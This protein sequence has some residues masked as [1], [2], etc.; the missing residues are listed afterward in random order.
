MSIFNPDF[1]PTPENVIDMMLL[2][3]TIEGKVILEPS[4]GNG[5]IIKYLKTNGAKDV[6]FC[7][8]E[9][10][11]ATISSN[12][13]R[14]VGDDFLKLN[15]EDVSHIDMIVANPPFS[16]D[17]DH[18]LKMWDIAPGGCT[19]ITLLNWNTYDLAHTKARRLLRH[20]V[21]ENGSATYLGDVFSTAERKTGVAIGL[22]KLYKPKT[23]GDDEFD[24]YFD[25]SEE[26]EQQENGLMGYNEVRNIVNRYVG[27][28]KMF[29]EV[30]DVNNKIN[31]LIK[32]ISSGL[33][34]EFGAR[35]RKHYTIERD[36]FKKELQKSAWRTVFN[37]LNMRKYTTERVMSQLNKFVEQ[38]EKVPFTM[39]NIYKMIEMIIGTH[40]DR[41]GR[42]LVEVFDWL[43]ERHKEN[44]VGLEG[45]KT[46]SMYFVGM[47]FVAPYCGLERGY[48]GQPQI[49]YSSS[50]EKMDDLT[51]AICFLTGKDYNGFETLSEFFREK[52]VPNDDAKKASEL[53]AQETGI[54]EKEADYVHNYASRYAAEITP[55]KY[56]QRFWN[57]PSKFSKDQIDKFK[58][59]YEKW[60]FP[61][62][63]WGK[64]YETKNWGQ[65]YDWGF[66]EIKVYKKGTLHAKFK[67]EKVWE[68][69]NRACAK[70]KGWAL[71]TN[72]GSDV[73]RKETGVEV[74]SN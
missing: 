11:L 28:V 57:I 36:T 32:P 3:E 39:S 45:W 55:E 37:K 7:E 59:F 18:I 20:I 26:Y 50:G 24:G 66:F 48:R 70:A 58:D 35:S 56:Y 41:M 16:K 14:M 68:M 73:R 6:L 8:K 33:D 23:G 2:G 30:M 72:T 61:E 74:Y 38:Q 1:F 10:E 4:A 29:D 42:V 63:H 5:N 64:K 51:K 52:E 69:F 22:I 54:S 65:W 19:I 34:I 53:L 9:S 13:G 31:S 60:K 62:K 15:K 44:R 49:R 17:E 43:T 40:G 25:M 21:A 46:N 71:P 47:K 27:A 67:D 12:L